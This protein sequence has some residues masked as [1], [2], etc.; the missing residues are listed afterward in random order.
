MQLPPAPVIIN[1]N[2]SLLSSIF[3]WCHEE[4][5]AFKSR[6]TFIIMEVP[7]KHRVGE[8]EF[9]YLANCGKELLCILTKKYMTLRE[10]EVVSIKDYTADIF[11]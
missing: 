9:S 4:I 11:V 10:T 1:L 5:P 3:K 8:A 6:A 2:V 7:L